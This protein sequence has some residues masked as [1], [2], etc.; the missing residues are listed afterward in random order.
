MNEIATADTATTADSALTADGWFDL[1][2]PLDWP[3]AATLAQ[4]WPAPAGEV[5]PWP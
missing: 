3:V 2:G 4:A 1:I 5:L